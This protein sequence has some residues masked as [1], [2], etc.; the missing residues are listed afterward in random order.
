[1]STEEVTSAFDRPYRPA[2]IAIA[3]RVGRLLGIGRGPISV[4]RVL[5]EAKR[6]VGMS[7]FGDEAFM[8][9]LELLIDSI[10]R[11]AA[12]NPVGRMI[13]RGR[14]VGVLINKLVAQD[15]IKKH[16]EI[17]DIPVQKEWQKAFAVVLQNE[18][19]PIGILVDKLLGKQDIVIKSLGHRFSSVGE[20]AGSTILGDG[21]VALVLDTGL[22]AL[23]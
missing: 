2:A 20:V 6:K 19:A 12:L 1:M 22:W 21:R 8:E 23:N 17:L 14:I 9:P 11:E 16:P 13:I 3:N 4:D 5:A 10:N 18:N 15:T 7:D